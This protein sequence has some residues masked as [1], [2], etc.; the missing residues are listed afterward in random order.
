MRQIY[1]LGG[2]E[3][4][5]NLEIIGQGATATI[6][7]DGDKA[8][9]LYVNAPADEAANEA[10]RQR[11][12]YDAGLPVPAVIDVRYLDEKTTALDMEF[13]DGK[14]LFWPEMTEAEQDDAIQVLVKLQCKVHK[15]QALG[16]PKQ[17]DKIQWK[18]QQSSHLTEEQKIQLLHDLNQL[19]TTSTNLCHGDIHP[20]NIL[21]DGK[22][23][24]IIDWVD[25]AAGSPLS[26]A[27]RTYLLI[28]Q[29]LPP[30]AEIYLQ[31]FC[32]EANTKPEDVL[33][34]LPV[35]AATRLAENIDENAKAWLLNILQN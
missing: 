1:F 21:Y 20:L 9:K 2:M 18:I 3:N 31:T 22:K 5:L 13:I 6:Y 29:L 27:C 17:A 30:Q 15:I 32:K 7:R 28:K 33:A 25:A 12:A 34:W 19:D 16:Q 35:I 8:V 23:Y 4:M 24:W 26:D 11:F 10:A 14:P